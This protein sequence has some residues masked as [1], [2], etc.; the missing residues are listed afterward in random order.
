MNCPSRTDNVDGREGWNQSPNLLSGASRQDFNGRTNTRLLRILDPDGPGKE[1]PMNQLHELDPSGEKSKTDSTE[2]SETKAGE[3]L[4]DP[5]HSQNTSTR[6]PL[7][8]FQFVKKVV[9]TYGKFIG[10]GFMV[11]K[12]CPCKDGVLNLY[13]SRSRL[14]TLIQAII[15]PT[16]QQEAAIA[17]SSYLSSSCQTLLLSIFNAFVSS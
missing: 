8:L 1:V 6:T 11:G 3:F 16:L 4:V 10:P 2:G 12:A 13:L 9:V 14:H 17:S 15:Q 5:A 7:F